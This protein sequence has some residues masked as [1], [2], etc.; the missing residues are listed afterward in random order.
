MT[1]VSP[2]LN[3][4]FVA[5]R[6]QCIEAVR[7]WHVNLQ[8][9]IAEDQDRLL[10]RT[11]AWF[12][13]DLSRWLQLAYF[14]ICARLTDPAKQG[15]KQNLTAE[16]LVNELKTCGLPFAEAEAELSNMQAYRQLII[17]ARHKLL[18]HYDV[19]SVRTEKKLGEHKEDEITNFLATLNRFTDA[20]G[21]A[22]G[23]GPMDYLSQ[24]SE[25][26]VIDLI[27]FLRRGM[28]EKVD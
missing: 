17:E 13:S 9:G 22:I 20:V 28:A 2:E 18:V 15:S 4:D 25:G 14:V 1:R 5:Y 3:D 12:F 16:H 27:R 6:A 23:E 24:S 8:L 11:A 19:E 21:R 7:L 26:D 10:S